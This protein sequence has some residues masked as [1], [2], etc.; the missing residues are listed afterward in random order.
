MRWSGPGGADARPGPG[1][2]TCGG[3]RKAMQMMRAPSA[4]HLPVRRKNGTPAQRQLSTR[5]SARRR[6]RRL[7]VGRDARL[8]AVAPVLARA[9]R[10]PGSSGLTERKTLIFSS[11]GARG[12]SDGG[13]S[14]ATNASTC[15]RCV[16][17]MSRKAPVALVE[18]AARADRRA[19]RARRSARGRCARGSRSARGGRWRSAGRGCS[20]PPP[21]RGSGRCGRSGPRRRPRAP[22]R[23]A[24][25][26]ARSVP[27]GFSMITRA[28]SASRRRRASARSAGGGRRHADR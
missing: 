24:R 13:G 2:S 25:A 17:T 4:M 14:I 18:L 9:R 15:S 11:H 16:T 19:S 12:S 5:T 27:N 1:T 8:V 3:S 7:G 21:C 28:R 23:S 26:P 6:S 10:R 20:A 22:R